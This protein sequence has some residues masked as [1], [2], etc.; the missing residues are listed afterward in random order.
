MFLVE[1]LHF[2]FGCWFDVAPASKI[3][4]GKGGAYGN[5]Y[6]ILT[7]LECDGNENCKLPPIV[8]A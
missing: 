7:Y 4:Y 2:L 1:H 3:I 6:C 8:T 5:M